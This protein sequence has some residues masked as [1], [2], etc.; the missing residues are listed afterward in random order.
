MEDEINAAYREDAEQEFC[1][2]KTVFVDDRLKQCREEAHQ[3]E[4]DHADRDIWR[5]DAGVEEY[6]MQTQQ[7]SD[8]AH[9]GYVFEA[10]TLQFFSEK[11]KQCHQNRRP[12]HAMPYKYRGVELD[13]P[14]QHPGKTCNEYRKM[15]K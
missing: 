6:P 4:A 5:L 13:E 2:W 12:R 15:Q 14:P 3:R 8:A 1:Y 11:K 7:H 9:L 10:V